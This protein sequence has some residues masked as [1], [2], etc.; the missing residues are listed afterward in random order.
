MLPYFAASGHNHYLKSARLYLQQMLELQQTHPEVYQSFLAGH[1]IVRRSDRIWTGMPLDLLIEQV[2]MRSL[3]TNGG[4]TRGSGMGE[5]ERLVWL[6]S[7]PACAH[8]NIAMQLVT[9]V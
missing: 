5:N 3:K 6:L 1:H 9:G 4:L 2:L 8:V 7:M